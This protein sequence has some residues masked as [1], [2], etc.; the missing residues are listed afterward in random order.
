MTKKS[1][2]TQSD[3]SAANKPTVS[4]VHQLARA[5]VEALKAVRDELHRKAAALDHRQGEIEKQLRENDETQ[6]RITREQSTLEDERK[7]FQEEHESS[8]AI[9]AEHDREI[10]EKNEHLAALGAEL[11]TLE[12]KLQGQQ[13][14]AASQAMVNEPELVEAPRGAVEAM[15][16]ASASGPKSAGKNGA[17]ASRKLRRNTKRKAIGI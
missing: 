7:R 9:A 8:G 14:V 15:P 5:A 13:A 6:A 16:R 4:E 2:K 12:A 1:T 17:A 11:L 10:A 3:E